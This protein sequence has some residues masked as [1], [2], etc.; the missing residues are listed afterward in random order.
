VRIGIWEVRGGDQHFVHSRVMSWVAFDRALRIAHDRGLPAPEDQ[1][2]A[3]RAEIYNEIMDKGW[4][5]EKQSFVQYYG[6]DAIDASALLISLTK[7]TA[8]AD[9]RMLST[10]DRILKELSRPPHVY[11]YDIEAAAS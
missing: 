5:E 1:W 4:S 9:P 3:I 6:G 2:I 11:R 8:A 7:L 10:I